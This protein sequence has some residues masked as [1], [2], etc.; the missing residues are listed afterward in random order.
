MMVAETWIMTIITVA[1]GT[2]SKK[3]AS[4]ASILR[5]FRLARLSRMARMLRTM[6]ELMILI[7]GMI[8][9]LRSVSF[10]MGLLVLITYT[11]G[12]AFCQLS[13]GFY[14]K[15]QYFNT[16]NE[17]MFTLTV[18]GLFLDNLTNCTNNIKSE[19]YALLLLFVLYIGLANLTVMNM[20]VGVLCDVISAVS[21][22]EKEE[23][24]IAY[25]NQKLAQLMRHI[26][27][28][29]DLEVSR[30]EFIKILENPQAVQVLDDVGVDTL[31]LV[32]CVDFIFDTLDDDG[33]PLPIP[34]TDFM[35][36]VLDLRGSNIATVK[37]I[38]ELR[39]FMTNIHS[40]LDPMICDT[41]ETARRKAMAKGEGRAAERPKSANTKHIV[42]LLQH[43]R[44]VE[45]EWG[46]V[47]GEVRSL[48]AAIHK[49]QLE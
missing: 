43:T 21:E 6:P 24:S 36:V 28:D 44:H 27:T 25:A 26:D 10:V 11:F 37:D 39:K 42:S 1:S 48:S 4:N 33:H 49:S 17:A 35:G 47:L 12:I 19:S 23:M 38:V 31:A 22:T 18:Y 30:D 34:F 15:Q 45:E 20:L 3:G 7:R 16:V 8:A 32:D 46:K 9:A 41:L 29:G 14:M 40:S 2:S 5:L 13:T